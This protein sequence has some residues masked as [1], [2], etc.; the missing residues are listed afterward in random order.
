MRD[1]DRG[2]SELLGYFLIFSLVILTI[3]MA[4]TAGLVGLQNAQEFQETTNV[5]HGFSAFANDVDDVARR[6]APGRSTE[7]ALTDATLSLDRT[8]E[9]TVRIDDG[10]SVENTTVD[11]YSLVY[12]SGSGTTITYTSGALIRQDGADSVLFRRPNLAL[13]NDTVIIPLVAL[14][15]TDEGAVGG[16]RAVSVETR[17]TGTDV[18]YDD[19][20]DSVT[21]EVTSPHAEAWYRYLDSEL[22][23]DP[24]DGGTVECR[25]DAERAYVSVERVSVRFQ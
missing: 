17:S 25:T 15:P 3:A 8:A 10:E 22:D 20:V 9:I 21:V 5:Q 19:D 1:R 16:S 7:I 2:Q 24:P 4:G 6:G 11:A 14:S 12:D 13:S 23:C 18:V